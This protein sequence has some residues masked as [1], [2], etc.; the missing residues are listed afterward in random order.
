MLTD[1]AISRVHAL[2]IEIAG[3]LYAVDAG[4]TNGL[5]VGGSRVPL[6]GLRPGMPVALAAGVATLEWSFRH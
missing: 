1:H 4:S 2:V 3:K 6:A 5:W